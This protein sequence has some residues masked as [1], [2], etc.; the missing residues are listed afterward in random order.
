MRFDVA[1]LYGHP[2][3]N[4]AMNSVMS[5]KFRVQKGAAMSAME[6]LA[7]YKPM[8]AEMSKKLNVPKGAARSA[9]QSWSGVR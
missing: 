5:K 8:N 1:K 4:R 2:A 7:L 6:S 9:M 3:L